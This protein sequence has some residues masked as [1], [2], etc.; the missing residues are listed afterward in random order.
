MKSKYSI[1]AFFPA[2]ND[3]GTIASM[4]I[5]T[6]DVLKSLTNDFEVI[7]ID[8]HSPDNSGKISDELAKKYKEVRVI[9]HEKNKGYGGAL[10]SGFKA[11]KKDLIFYTDG[12]G[13]YNVFEIKKLLPLMTSNVDMVNGYKIKRN[14]P[15]HRVILGKLYHLGIK[16][17]FGLK[18]KDVDCDFRLMRKSIFDKINLKSNSGLICAEM[19]KKIQDAGF[20]IREVGV[21]HYFRTHGKS[22]FFNFVR[23]FRVGIDIL[24]LWWKLQVRK[25]S[26][27]AKQPSP[28]NTEVGA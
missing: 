27:A 5:K 3:E 4:V 9:H 11:A 2:Y 25:S 21:S 6:V 22:Q 15:L 26:S 10:K 19:M 28:Q 16:F 7:V 12:D 24:K 20:K 23:V 18:I 17:M 13:Q 1:S 14:D 8:D